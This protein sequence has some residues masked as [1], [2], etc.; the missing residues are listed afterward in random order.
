MG[1]MR[2]GKAAEYLGI[3]HGT[4]R[5]WADEGK[6]SYIMFGDERR[7]LDTDLDKFL[8]IDQVCGAER[9]RTEVLYIRVSGSSGQESSLEAQE[10][11]L[12]E[13]SKDGAQ[14]LKVYKDW[15]SGLYEN[16][17]GLVKLLKDAKNQGG[18]HLRN[19]P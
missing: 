8:K 17:P 10:T 2:T 15:G 6:V 3:T 9:V 12:R 14:I 18:F 7:F 4:L 13:S 19:L 11:E 1:R 5:I 16:R